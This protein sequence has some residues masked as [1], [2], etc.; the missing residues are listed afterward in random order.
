[1][2]HINDI[3]CYWYIWSHE[4]YHDSNARITRCVILYIRECE[5]EDEDEDEKEIGFQL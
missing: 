3:E 1:M 4:S 2:T 5:D